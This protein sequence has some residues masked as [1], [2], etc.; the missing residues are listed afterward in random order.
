MPGSRFQHAAQLSDALTRVAALEVRL[1][2]LEAAFDL[3]LRRLSE[4]VL[5]ALAVRPATVVAADARTET[6]FVPLARRL[7]GAELAAPPRMEVSPD[8]VAD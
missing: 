8:D 2:D 1:A 6:S 3:L 7:P 5:P 4:Q